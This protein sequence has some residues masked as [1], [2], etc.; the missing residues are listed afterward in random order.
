M[1]DLFGDILCFKCEAI[2]RPTVEF[3]DNQITAFVINSEVNHSFDM[4]EREGIHLLNK[5]RCYTFWQIHFT[6]VEKRI[7][8]I[9]RV[10][11]L[12]ISVENQYIFDRFCLFA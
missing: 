12:I 5:P 2:F 1:S 9:S 4:I 11:A 6:T 8:F 7:G 10:F 3:R